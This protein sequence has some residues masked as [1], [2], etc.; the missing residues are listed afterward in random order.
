M[1]TLFCNLSLGCFV[2]ISVALAQSWTD[3][4]EYDLA[5]LLRSE[6]V[7]ANQLALIS[8]WKQKYP[9]SALRTWRAELELDAAKEASDWK[10]V[11]AAAQEIFKADPDNCTGMYWTTLLTPSA[12]PTP[13]TL[14]A[15]GD[16]ARKLLAAASTKPRAL[17]DAEW[18]Q[19]KAQFTALGH[20]TLSWIEWQKQ[21]FATAETELR[22]ALQA[23]PKD[24]EIS[25][26]LGASL[27]L[28]KVREKQLESIWHLGRA[29]YT[30]GEQALPGAKRRDAHALLQ[31]VYV[32][33]HGSP[34]GLDAVGQQTLA[35]SVPPSDFRLETAAE[36]AVRLQD[37]EL[38][39]TNPNLAAWV[40]LKRRLQGEGGEQYLKNIS[41][42]AQL[43]KG[44]V[45]RSAPAARPKEIGIAMSDPAVEEIVLK[46]DAPFNGPLERGALVEFEAYPVSTTTSPFIVSMTVS[47]TNLRLATKT[48]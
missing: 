13:E 26:W 43:F 32:S 21:S 25:S 34:E 8:Q 46:L 29:V 24:T 38:A 6:M 16:A 47:R 35:A 22:A 15:G 48:E 39:R 7:P 36:A 23:N 1:K 11:L 3:R 27:A 20:K 28:Q 40:I 2:S 33:W 45:V 37:E 44:F 41:S 42:T 17:S 10:Q 30:D 18:Q 4:G 19:N 14:A 31:A 9:D 12:E 5:L